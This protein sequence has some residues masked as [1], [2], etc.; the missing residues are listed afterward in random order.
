MT[1]LNQLQQTAE[2]LTKNIFENTYNTYRELCIYRGA[3]LTKAAETFEALNLDPEA[4]A[5][6]QLTDHTFVEDATQE[7]MGVAYATASG[8]EEAINGNYDTNTIVPA[9]LWLQLIGE[10][11]QAILEVSDEDESKIA[12]LDGNFVNG[13]VNKMINNFAS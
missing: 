11:N 3:V 4:D 5:L 10:T 12:R 1:T 6:N 7:E 8:I 2:A 9:I 13:I